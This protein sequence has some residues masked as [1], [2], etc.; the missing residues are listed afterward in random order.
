MDNSL[1]KKVFVVNSIAGFGL[2]T[3]IYAASL[4]FIPLIEL[5]TDYV[6]N[7]QD[8]LYADEMINNITC[9]HDPDPI[10]PIDPVD[11]VENKNDL[12]SHDLDIFHESNENPNAFPM[13]ND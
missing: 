2:A 13:E 12:Q 9:N 4:M 8:L 1:L 7:K 3:G 11:H 5:V 10:D 6:K